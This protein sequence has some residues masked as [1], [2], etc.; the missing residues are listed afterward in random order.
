MFCSP[1]EQFSIIKI[2]SLNILFLDFSLTSI[3]IFGII[4]LIFVYCF[5]R[6]VSEKNY[7][8]FRPW[9]FIAYSLLKLVLGLILD[10]VGKV[11]LKYMNLI[12]SV[13]LLIL[14]LNYISLVPYSFTLTARLGVCLTL[15]I[16]VWTGATIL[17]LYLNGLNFISMFLPNNTPN[18]LVVPFILIETLGYMIRPISLGV[19]LVAN[20]AAGHLL[21]SLGSSF[22]YFLLINDTIWLNVI[23]ILPLIFLI[24]FSYLEIAVAFIQAY[25]FSLL[26]ISYIN[27]SINLH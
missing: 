11:G 17:A 2:L 25:V 19:R 26:S 10:N 5:I 13:F 1:L 27:D 16:L 22:I 6:F 24:V 20:L 7:T 14:M 18:L 23:A 21:L 9:R 8:I 15:S 4:S 12:L 3:S